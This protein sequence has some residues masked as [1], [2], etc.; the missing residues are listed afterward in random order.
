MPPSSV[1]GLAEDLVLIEEGAVHRK[2]VQRQSSQTLRQSQ[3]LAEW[4]IE[5]FPARYPSVARGGR[6]PRTRI[7]LP[8]RIFVTEFGQRRFFRENSLSEN[9]NSCYDP[10]HDGTIG[11][12]PNRDRDRARDRSSHASH[13]G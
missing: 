10:R 4:P 9:L 1:G 2:L 11:N 7:T 12:G 3:F 5:G 13:T 8:L 6:T